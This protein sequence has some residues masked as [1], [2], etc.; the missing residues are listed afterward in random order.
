MNKETYLRKL[1]KALSDLDKE[2]VDEIIDD[3][4]EHFE[5]GL[6]MGKSEQEIASE[7]G[8]PKDVAKD[9]LGYAPKK[10]QKQVVLKFSK[11]LYFIIFLVGLVTIFP[12]LLKITTSVITAVLWFILVIVLIGVVIAAILIF[13][14]KR[15]IGYAKD[16]V[17][18]VT[19]NG[20]QSGDQV[21]VNK[22]FNF[23]SE[24][25]ENIKV[26][27]TLES[28]HL[29][30][31]TS[32]QIQIHIQGKTN[33][34]YDDIVVTSKNKT[35]TIDTQKK[36]STHVN[37]SNLTIEISVPSHLVLN[38]DCELSLGNVIVDH[39]F[40]Q[41]QINVK[42]GE[43]KINAPIPQID[44]DSRMG[45]I[46]FTDFYG[47]GKV[48]SKMGSIVFLN[49]ELLKGTLE[50]S[51]QLGSIKSDCQKIRI[52]PNSNRVVIDSSD[53]YLVVHSKMGSIKFK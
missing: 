18:N 47:S 13:Y 26:I 33:I 15:K 23:D 4:Q 45:S 12:Y 46:K 39:S 2:V 42:T 7:L 53:E 6:L 10:N 17:R 29:K 41:C 34:S 38:L 51:T 20:K 8:N 31:T 36:L 5:N 32:D 16:W 22:H 40:N 14:L 9:Y 35:V 28:V 25:I 44:I 24:G 49:S 27:S 19:F 1:R 50:L 11:V 21:Y 52:N 43:V 48:T 37:Q 30:P 3:Y